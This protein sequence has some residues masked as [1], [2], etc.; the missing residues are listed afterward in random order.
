[1]VAY[2]YQIC[3]RRV[4]ETSQGKYWKLEPLC[5][6]SLI[7]L[8]AKNHFRENSYFE[9]FHLQNIKK[10]MST[11]RDLM[12]EKMGS[13][14]LSPIWIGAWKL[15]HLTWMA[16]YNR[17]SW[18]DL[19][20]C[21]VGNKSVNLL[22]VLCYHCCLIGL[23]RSGGRICPTEGSTLP[24]RGVGGG[25]KSKPQPANIGK[26]WSEVSGKNFQRLGASKVWGF[27]WRKL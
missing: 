26:G 11:G 2:A 7:L 15:I 19:N 22:L 24:Q 3:N 5:A 14:R 1:M 6:I 16:I 4:P 8:R 21:D 23:C 27:N 10:P 17:W 18:K 13:E 25:S 12:S 20:L 9:H